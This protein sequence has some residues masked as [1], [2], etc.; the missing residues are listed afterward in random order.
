MVKDPEK[1]RA[2][3]D[4]ANPE[5]VERMLALQPRVQ[6]ALDP[7][8]PPD[9]VARLGSVTYH[10]LE[11]LAFLP[12]SGTTMRRFAD[13]VGITGAAATALANR[14]V[15]QGLAVRRYDPGDRRKVWLAPTRAA[16]GLVKTLRD[17][18]RNYMSATLSRLSPEQISTFLEVLE[19]LDVEG[20]ADR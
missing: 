12:E 7:S 2:E 9:V 13:A 15:K 20:G 18:Q 5:L 10:Q 4:A 16:L 8:L 11:A 1:A 6:R 14:M 3:L 19:A 17:W